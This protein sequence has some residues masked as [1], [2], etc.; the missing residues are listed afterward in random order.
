MVPID[1]STAG[2]LRME[3]APRRQSMELHRRAKLNFVLMYVITSEYESSF[4][5]LI[6]EANLCKAFDADGPAPLVHEKINGQKM[7]SSTSIILCSYFS[8]LMNS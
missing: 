5:S 3:R 6:L 4:L 2:R 8:F 1:A 7:A